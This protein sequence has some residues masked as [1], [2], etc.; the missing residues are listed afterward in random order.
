[1]EKE[2]CA[3]PRGVQDAGAHLLI[4]LRSVKHFPTP[5]KIENILRRAVAACPV[6][7]LNISDNRFS[8]KSEIFSVA[9]ALFEVSE[10][11]PK[12]TSEP[13]QRFLHSFGLFQKS[14]FSKKFYCNLY[15]AL[16]KHGI[17]KRKIVKF[18]DINPPQRFSPQ[19]VGELLKNPP[20]ILAES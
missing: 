11:L 4:A 18:N 12:T 13:S 6:T 3:R 16:R 20:R 2:H 15:L 7:F 9:Q 5:P 14:L 10:K 1:M 19:N 17:I 8:S